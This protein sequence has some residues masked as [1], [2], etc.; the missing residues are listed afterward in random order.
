MKEWPFAATQ[1]NRRA[2]LRSSFGGLLGAY[3]ASAFAER[4]ALA[5]TA[6][7]PKAKAKSCIVLWM[8][9]GP[10]HIDTWDPK[11]GV[12]T[13][14]PFKAIRTKAPAIQVAQHLPRVA[15]QADKIAIVRSM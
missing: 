12:S 10:S 14:G 2:F 13:G 5:Q 7:A 4:G 3:L 15:E 6:Q 8:N 1:T 11:P 9:G